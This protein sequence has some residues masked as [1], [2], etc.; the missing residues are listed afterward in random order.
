MPHEDSHAPLDAAL[1]K[2]HRRHG[3]RVRAGK[4]RLKERGGRI[5]NRRLYMREVLAA[6]KRRQE[7]APALRDRTVRAT[8]GAA[9]GRPA[10]SDQTHRAVQQPTIR[11]PCTRL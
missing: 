2:R 9:M 7:K 3:G 11:C 5:E 6:G 1:S 4:T 8:P 10:R